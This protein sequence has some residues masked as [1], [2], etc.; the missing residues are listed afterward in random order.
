M[1]DTGADKPHNVNQLNQISSRSMV[2]PYDS[3]QVANH[4]INLSNQRGGPMSIMRLLKVTY[5][6]QGWTL[7][8]LERPLV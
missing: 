8:V 3:R 4:L 6:T 5:M 7:A 1:L 2:S